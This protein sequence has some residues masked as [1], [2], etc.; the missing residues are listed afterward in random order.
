MSSTSEAMLNQG[1]FEEQEMP[2]QMGFFTT[3]PQNL[4]SSPPLMASHQSL[5]AFNITAAA[6]DALPN[7]AANLSETLISSLTS[8]KHRQHLASDFGGPQHLS[9][10]RSKA[11]FWA[12][13]EVNERLG[14]KKM[15][16]DHDHLG[17]SAM[18]MKRIKARRKVREPRF[19]FKTMSDVDVLD[20]GYKWRKYGQ[21][22]VKNTQHPRSYYRCTQDNC[23]VK[24]RVE[25]LAE[26][27][28]MVI[29]TYEGR[30]VHSPS[31]DLDDSPPPNSQ[32]NNFFW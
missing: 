12:W 29:T 2:T 24:K 13:G 21:K 25:R 17:V 9:L 19:C 18:K 8:Q 10:Q 15:G 6:A 7:S 23:R 26:D 20:D 32:L 4:T 5:K 31:H 27:P 1:L 14:S 11:N 22:V 30:H 16:D 28:R 3:F